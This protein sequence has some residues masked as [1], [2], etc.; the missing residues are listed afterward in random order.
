MMKRSPVR[1]DHVLRYHLYVDT[2]AS[3]FDAFRVELLERSMVVTGATFDAAWAEVLD[4]VTYMRAEHDRAPIRHP[5]IFSP[6]AII[7]AVEHARESAKLGVRN[8]MIVGGAFDGC[9]HPV[10]DERVR[11]L[12]AALDGIELLRRTAGGVH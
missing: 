1:T 8:N 2:A 3:K 7:T 4:V 11:S 12:C 6:F 5:S 10:H 9:G